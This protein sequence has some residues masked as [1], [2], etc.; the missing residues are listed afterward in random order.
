MYKEK[1]SGDFGKKNINKN[2][3]EIILDGILFSEI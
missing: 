3:K 1:N 2:L